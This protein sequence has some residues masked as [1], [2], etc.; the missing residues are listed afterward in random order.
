MA[1][2][3]NNKCI[4]HQEDQHISEL[5]SRS[6]VLKPAISSSVILSVEDLSKLEQ[7]TRNFLESSTPLSPFQVNFVS[8]TERKIV[9]EVQVK[10]S[11]YSHVTPV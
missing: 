5:S 6:E 3:D 9:I 4:H 10:L 7:E 11:R 2:T 1:A 8:L